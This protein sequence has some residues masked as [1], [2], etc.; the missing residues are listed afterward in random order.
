MKVTT[1]KA[2]QIGFFA[3][4]SMLI[5]SVVGIGIF[6]KNN[7][8]FKINSFNEIGVIV[9]WI[10]A[11]FI[12][13]ATAISFAIFG[14]SKKQGAGLSGSLEIFKYKKFA[15]FI[16]IAQPCFYNA[17][18]LP[19]LCF[20]GAEAFFKVILP[21]NETPPIWLLF[22]TTFIIFIL[23][24][25]I[26]LISI[27]IA[28]T[29]QII[30]TILKFLPII[31]FGIVGIVLGIKNWNYSLA[32]V[33]VNDQ[34]ITSSN[35]V[36][37]KGNFSFTNILTALPSILFA[38]DSFLNI[39]NI[40]HRIK[41]GSKRI[42]W[43][44]VFGIVCVAFFYLLLTIGQI[45]VSEGTVFG[46]INKA[47]NYD[48]N[49]I[50]AVTLTVDV[51]ILIS[52]LGVVNSFVLVDINAN[53]YLINQKIIFTSY[54]LSKIAN[55][56]NQYLKGAISSFISF[57]FFFI[58]HSI[59]GIIQNTDAYVD[60]MSNFSSVFFFLVYGLIII[61]ALHNATKRNRYYKKYP[62][63][64]ELS[65]SNRNYSFS[66][67]NKKEELLIRKQRISLPAKNF[68][69]LQTKPWHYLVW[70]V[71]I[72]GCCFVFL[73]QL[74]YGFTI[75]TWL[76]PYN[77]TM[78]GFGLYY[79]NNVTVSPWVASLIFFIFI[80]IFIV[81]PF[82]NDSIIKLIH[83]KN[84]TLTKEIKTSLLV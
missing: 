83:T 35:A 2:K 50:K 29:L 22:V 34:I 84:Q 46:V 12:A 31:V 17:A 1:K 15:R 70:T 26:N 19:S 21:P 23:F 60:L 74:F 65:L 6:F 37:T 49:I 36:Y 8:I 71:A 38:Y 55:N 18:L 54:W 68:V 53:Q 3:A 51:I 76:D 75:Q 13:I 11:A 62:F 78:F 66:F 14:F 52:I 39:G 57:S 79:D 40:Q 10:V 5:G 80:T 30:S 41:N 25:V 61:C 20:F 67:F 69:D 9:S 59:V 24:I 27:K 64:K 82:F 28:A 73:Y 48:A 42:S 4:V 56:K 43:I 45:F 32:S 16:A 44:L 81:T 33:A 47:W 7:S 72:V 63:A 77:K 58:I